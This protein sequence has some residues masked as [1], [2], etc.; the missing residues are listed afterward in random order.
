MNETNESF[1]VGASFGISYERS[2]I[3]ESLMLTFFP[4]PEDLHLS[5][6]SAALMTKNALLAWGNM[7]LSQPLHTPEQAV[8]VLAASRERSEDD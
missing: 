5:D 4:S 2:R 1:V 6:G 8:A 7:I 3:M